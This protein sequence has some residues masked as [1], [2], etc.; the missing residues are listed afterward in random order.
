MFYI[1]EHCPVL[2]VLLAWTRSPD[3]PEDV[4]LTNPI[5]H[6]HLRALTW[7]CQDRGNLVCPDLSPLL[8]LPAIESIYLHSLHWERYT[9]AP[10]LPYPNLI[11]VRRF[12]HL[13]RLFIGPLWNDYDGDGCVKLLRTMPALQILW[14][15]WKA[16]MHL[17]FEALSTSGEGG[18]FLPS[19]EWLRI[20]DVPGRDLTESRC[21]QW[22]VAINQLARLRGARCMKTTGL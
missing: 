6:T 22:H 9:Q 15:P 11:P 12:R 19:L 2:E 18:F 1:L 13:T 20:I 21:R 3:S 16:R 10:V 5:R 8:D 14:L 7:L 17:L 4:P